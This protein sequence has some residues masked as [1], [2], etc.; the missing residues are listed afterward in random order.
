MLILPDSEIRALITESKIIPDGLCPL[1]RQIERNHHR[2]REFEVTGASGNLFMLSTRQSMLNV[3]DFSVI[4][5]Y[6][7]PGINT[8][9]RL[10]R[11]NG[12]SHYHS[13]AI[14]KDGFRDFHKHTATERYQRIG[15]LKE[16]HFAEIDNRY[17]N[18][19]SA[20]RCLLED[21]GF[22]SPMEDFPL[23]SGKVQ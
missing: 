15:G 18:L 19:E 21:C 13:N 11:Y 17:W 6:K 5:G 22:Q 4:L 7:M 8:I 3:V 16:D 20:V 10:R 1:T 14:E 23:F 2:R 9:L 12:K